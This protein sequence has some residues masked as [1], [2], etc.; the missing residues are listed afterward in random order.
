M[1]VVR[2]H[3]GMVGAAFFAVGLGAGIGCDCDYIQSTLCIECYM[4][5]MGFDV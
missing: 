1:A 5:K 2:V 4:V 3:V